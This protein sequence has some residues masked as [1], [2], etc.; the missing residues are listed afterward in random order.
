[1]NDVVQRA[2]RRKLFSR[3]LTCVHLPEVVVRDEV[4]VRTGGRVPA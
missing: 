4:L 1:V 2:E 3:K